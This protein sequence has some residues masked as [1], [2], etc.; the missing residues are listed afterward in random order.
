VKNCSFKRRRKMNIW[1]A[2]GI[3]TLAIFSGM[4]IRYAWQ[5]T[6]QEEPPRRWVEKDRIIYLSLAPGKTIAIF[7]GSF[8]ENEE[9]TTE[10]IYTAARERKF[11]KIDAGIACWLSTN[12]SKSELAEMGLSWIIFMSGEKTLIALEVE[13]DGPFCPML[14]CRGDAEFKFPS[15]FYGFAFDAP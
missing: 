1:L 11:T 5:K 6:K 8:F 13:T 14:E 2:I 10:R 9:R 12:F 3:V 7:R 4:Y 15:E